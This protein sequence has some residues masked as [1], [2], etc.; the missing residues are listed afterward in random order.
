MGSRDEAVVCDEELGEAW[1]LT[2]GAVEWLA[3]HAG[4]EMCKKD[5]RR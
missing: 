5:R 1:Y 3:S 2:P 4:R